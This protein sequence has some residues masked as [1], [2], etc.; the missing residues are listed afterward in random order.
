M[1]TIDAGFGLSVVQLTVQHMLLDGGD[2][3]AF[4]GLRISPWGQLHGSGLAVVTS[5]SS[6]VGCRATGTTECSC[7]EI[8]SKRRFYQTT[9][10]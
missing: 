3:W 10:A 9:A 7:H 2:S 5:M 1:H 6:Q 8:Q 4:S